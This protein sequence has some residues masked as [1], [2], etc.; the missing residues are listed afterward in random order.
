MSEVAGEKPQDQSADHYPDYAAMFPQS[1]G[2]QEQQER[3]EVLEQLAQRSENV[4]NKLAEIKLAHPELLAQDQQEVAGKLSFTDVTN[5]LW[6]HVPGD[7]R[8]LGEVEGADAALDADEALELAECLQDVKESIELLETY[9]GLLNDKTILYK[10]LHDYNGAEPQLRQEADD[11]KAKGLIRRPIAFYVRAL[12][13]AV[14][15]RRE[16]NPM[17]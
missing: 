13:K 3:G 15:M 4:K 2:E 5:N 11:L 6:A 7:L 10:E 12:E 9:L 1:A 17:A 16:S 14:R 8:Y